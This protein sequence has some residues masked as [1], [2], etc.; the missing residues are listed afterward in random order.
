MNEREQDPRE[1]SRETTAA[2]PANSRHFN[3]SLLNWSS[4]VFAILQSVCGAF[5]A[6]SGIRLLIGVGA[7]AAAS[8][9]LRL[10]DRMHVDAIRTPMMLLALAGSLLNL[11][12]LWRV[13][14]LRKRPASAWRQQTVP[15]QKQR[16][17][18]FQFTLS[19]LTLV[20][21]AAEFV[22]HHILF[23]NR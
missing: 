2:Q 10:A 18:Y 3:T 6:L 16:S 4:F 19:V 23:P 8:G 17:E 22:A 5:I 21:L 15:K 7:F 20:L 11:F 13:W 9:A 1:L 12:A 14:R